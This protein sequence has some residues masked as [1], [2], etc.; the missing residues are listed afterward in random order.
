MEIDEN[1]HE[2]SNLTPGKLLKYKKKF[3]KM[4]EAFLTQYY[5]QYIEPQKL[6]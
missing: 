3:L 1:S 2:A 6:R 5:F 4:S